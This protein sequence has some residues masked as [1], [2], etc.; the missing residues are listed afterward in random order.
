M[1][2]GRTVTCLH[3]LYCGVLISEVVLSSYTCSSS[4]TI[5]QIV[6]FSSL[7]SMEKTA[8]VLLDLLIGYVC[9]HLII[10]ALF[11]F[12]L[13]ALFCVWFQMVFG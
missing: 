7:N 9:A 10:V 8:A 2:S 13:L 5:H 12:N 1:F 6:I 4:P 11:N 3:S